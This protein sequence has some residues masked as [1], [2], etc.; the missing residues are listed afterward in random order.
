MNCILPAQVAPIEEKTCKQC[1]IS[2]PLDCY[3]FDK[4]YQIYRT[5][6][7][8]CCAAWLRAYRRDPTHMERLREKERK[9]SCA[10][11]DYIKAWA[12]AHPENLRPGRRRRWAARAAR[13]RAARL[14]AQ[15]TA[16][17]TISLS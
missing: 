16:N 14:A 1:G 13:L 5:T 12:H 10:R 2:K 8:A 4:R 7:K 3:G 15:T 6:C 11:R 9:R 17:D